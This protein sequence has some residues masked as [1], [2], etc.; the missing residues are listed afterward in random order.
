LFFVIRFFFYSIMSES[1]HLGI[2][3]FKST[4]HPGQIKLA[5]DLC[6]DDISAPRFVSSK[7][8]DYNPK[9]QISDYDKLKFD[10][11]S[12]KKTSPN[13]S[14]E[15]QYSKILINFVINILYLIFRVLCMIF[16]YTICVIW[17]LFK[18]FICTI[19]RILT[20][21]RIYRPKALLCHPVRCN[22]HH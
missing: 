4:R 2:K 16:K 1:H 5:F 21:S 10:Y 18:I 22:H 19:F 3:N 11:F 8:D 17:C 6:T 14:Q 7:G 12:I 9:T 15:C 13:C 20:E